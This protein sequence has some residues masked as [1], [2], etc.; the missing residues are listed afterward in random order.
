MKLRSFVVLDV[1]LR[2]RR[3]NQMNQIS[4][5]FVEIFNLLV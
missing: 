5:K 2:M 3:T 1:E 4:D